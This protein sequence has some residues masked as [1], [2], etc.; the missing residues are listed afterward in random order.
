LVLFWIFWALLLLA[1]P[2]VLP[3][4]SFVSTRRIRGR[5]ARLED[6]IQAQ[7]EAIDALE[8]RLRDLT[9][10]KKEPPRV[11]PPAAVPPRPAVTPPVPAATP[12]VPAVTTPPVPTV[13][14]PPM[15]SVPTPPVPGITAPPERVVPPTPVVTRPVPPP[16][17]PSAPRPSPSPIGAAF[18]P[19]VPPPRVLAAPSFDWENLVGV[20]LFSGIA[21]IALV[22]AAVFFLKYS[23]DHGWL[24]PP[25][26]VAIGIIVAVALL[27][28][29]E[30]KVARQ[31][32]VTANALDAAA[33]A[34]LFATFFAAHALWHLIPAAVTFALLALVTVVAVLLSIRRDSIFIAVLGLLGGFATPALLSTGENRPIPLFAYL[35]MLNAGLAWVASRKKWSGLMVLTLVLTAVYQWGW[36][37]NFLSASQLPLA[38]GIFLVFG[39]ASFAALTLGSGG[40]R[41]M[42]VA[43]ERTGLGA[44]AMPLVFAIYLAAV[45]AYGG[46]AGLLFGFLL[47]LDAGML[48]I[49]LGRHS[50]FLHAAAAGATLLVFAIWLA[51]S[52]ASS[53]WITVT[54]FTVAFGAFY[55]LAPMAAAVAGCPLEGAGA[56]AVYAAPLLLFVFP[57]IAGIEP[58]VASPFVLFGAMFALLALIAWRALATEESGLYFVAAF[59]AVAAEAS[60]SATFLTPDRLRA[61]IALY[62]AFG[63]FYLGVP[64]IS[65]RLGRGLEPAWAPGAVLIASLILLLFL[66]AGESAPASLWG[67]ALLLAI[68]DAGLFIE[69]SAGNLPWLSAAGAVLSWVVLAVWWNRAAAAVGL[70]PS[71]LALIGLTLIMLVGH[72]WA[73]AQVR[74]RIGE[75]AATT[76]G[77]FRHGIYLALVGHLF[78]F[79]LAQNPLWSTPPWPLLG[80]L[81]VLTL[82]T[83]VSSLAVT[84][85]GLHAAGVTAAAVVVLAWAGLSPTASAPTALAAIE[86]V[87]AYALVWLPIAARM[88]TGTREAH[89]GA[90]CALFVGEITLIV[91]SISGGSPGIAIMTV[92]HAVNISVI[93]AIAWRHHWPYVAPAAVVPAFVASMA[94]QRMHPEP[95]AWRAVLLM[96]GSLYAVFTAYPFVLRGRARDYRDPH[97]TA[98]AASAFF[99]LVARAA[100]AQG[101]LTP[102]VGAVPVGEAAVLA[103]LLRDLLRLQPPG[104]RDLG[105]LAL[106]AGA[107]LAFVTIAIPLQLKH[108]WVTIGWMLEG[109][110]LS[111]LYRRIPHRGLLCW[112]VALLSVAFARLALNP[113]IFVYEPRGMRVLNWY[114]YTYLICGAALLLAGWWLSKTDDRI[115]R[116][117]R[118][119]SVLPAGGVILLFLLLNIEIADFYATGP[120]I[121]FRFGV[122]LAQDL[123]Y[124]IGWLIFGLVLL[125]AGIYLHNRL[126]RMAAVALIAVTTFKAFLYDMGSLGGLY[127]VAS[128]VGLAV[129]L[130]LVALALQKFVLQAPKEGP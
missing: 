109:A 62:T 77:G 8:R 29:C 64:L 72:A 33:I 25:V 103:L 39:I 32:A 56:R 97:V 48:A 60:W 50:H 10:Q 21:G 38:M 71:L 125:T 28:T 118:A 130:S 51:M 49:S 37:I 100:F 59:F 84:A 1:I 105:R 52:Y 63:A 110:A 107:A 94:W 12:P 24:A 112:A 2:F 83:S 6:L 124:T 45:P 99:F 101:G 90:T 67:L 120:E 66:A 95:A 128:L 81:A 61:A 121:T 65:R 14:T 92:A 76:T 78:L 85:G 4:V 43:L 16:P 82:A 96:A 31:Y 73:H 55:A 35:L 34:I 79:Y 93:L 17:P 70:L 86:A 75:A 89:I 111:W 42:D 106:V 23:I 7:R 69:S 54:L 91:V 41:P 9:E 15:P 108:Q 18:E 58:A 127:R 27:V 123:T 98:V 57:V 87:I 113:A 19:L 22:L 26:R 116:L 126:G 119:S 117:P 5:L 122:T 30:L 74:Q 115:A 53:A 129:S 36:V 40:D 102:F 11:A 3:V 80:S 13:P 114:L 46:H 68:L 104:D 47:L 44:S 20:K 88:R